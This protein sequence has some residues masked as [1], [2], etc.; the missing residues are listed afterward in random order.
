MKLSVIMTSLLTLVLAGCTQPAVPDVEIAADT[1]NNIIWFDGSVE[2]AFERA[3][4]DEKPLL[5]YWGAVWC[6]PCQEIKHTVFKSRRFIEQ[7]QSFVPVYLDGDTEA[8]QT[9]GERFRVRGYPT[10]IVFNSA[11]TEMT[12]IPGVSISPVTMTFWH[13]H[14]KALHPQHNWWRR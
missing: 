7:S 6:P 3:R 8:A 5:L 1:E 14:W 10:M 12:R 13:Q 9:A 2:A 4:E 11:G